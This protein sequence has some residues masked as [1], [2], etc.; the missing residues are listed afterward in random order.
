M[1]PSGLLIAAAGLFSLLGAVFQWSW[2]MDSAKARRMK[3]MF[4]HNGTRI[5]YG[6]LGTALMVVGTLLAL[7]IIH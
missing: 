6:I 4:G 1:D 2:F 7:R 3:A 5:F